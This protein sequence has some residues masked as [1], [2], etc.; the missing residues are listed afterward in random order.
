MQIEKCPKQA[1]YPPV[2]LLRDE[3]VC[4]MDYVDFLAFLYI[5]NN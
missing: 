2:V 4:A 1:K 5:E 3:W